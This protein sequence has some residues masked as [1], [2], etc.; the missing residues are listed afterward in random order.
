MS[1]VAHELR[2][3]TDRSILL[4][5]ACMMLVNG[6]LVY[7][8]VYGP[9]Q[10]YGPDSYKK[11]YRLISEMGPEDAQSYLEETLKKLYIIHDLILY[12]DFIPLSVNSNEHVPN[13]EVNEIIEWYESGGYLTYT[14]SIWW[15]I[16][17]IRSVLQHVKQTI[18]YDQYLR[19]ME[20]YANTLKTVSIFADQNTFGYR[21]II[22]T[23][24]DFQ[25]LRGLTFPPTQPQG[26]DIATRNFGTDLIAVIMIAAACLV[27]ITREKE[28]NIMTLVRTTYRGTISLLGAKCMAVILFSIAVFTLLYSINGI[29]GYIIYGFGNLYAPIQSMPDFYGSALRLSIG[30][31]LGLWIIAKLAVYSLIGMLTIMIAVVVHSS[32]NVFIWL[33]VLFGASAILYYT[34]PS[35]SPFNVIKY[36]NLIHFLQTDT[37]FSQYLNLNIAGYPFNY[38]WCFLTLVPTLTIVSSAVSFFVFSRRQNRGRSTVWIERIFGYMESLRKS[39]LFRH[40]SLLRHESYK[41]FIS[42]RVWIILIGFAVLQIYLYEPMVERIPDIDS[43]YYKKYMLQL[44]GTWSPEKHRQLLDE[45]ER[46][47]R[48]E[49]EILSYISQGGAD[50]QSYYLMISKL[51]S[52]TAPR[53]GLERAIQTSYELEQRMMERG[54]GW[55]LYAEGYKRLTAERNNTR[56]LQLGILLFIG[57]IASLTAIFSYEYETGMQRIVRTSEG[58]RM[59]LLIRKLL[60]GTIITL[61]LFLGVYVP[62]LLNVLKAYGTKSIEAPVYS[63]S[64]LAEVPWNLSIAGYLIVVHLIRLAGAL[65]A[66]LIIFSLAMRLQS[67]ILTALACSAV[68]V[69]P[70]LLSLI[71]IP[72][73]DYILLTPYISGNLLFK[74]YEFALLRSVKNLYFWGMMGILAVSIPI[75]VRRIAF[76]WNRACI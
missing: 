5:L 13:V 4:L 22:K 30:G 1:L 44:E 40:T 7:L 41:V 36:L 10:K 25:T 35:A 6:A 12:N 26:I 55:F 38:V 23:P 3:L 63:M 42:H 28:R 60:I 15:E 73:L 9:D 67:Y 49:Q 33:V 2:K 53:N 62:E 69:L 71:G 76:R 17:F 74:P 58:G 20:E 31:Y 18:K 56:D 34:I 21:N 32:R 54:D 51:A 46:I 48:E 70:I 29:F 61:V 14:S 45:M 27:L 8:Q 66:M 75:L 47:E 19:D 52:V 50:D 43:A 72:W 37:L 57:M 65:L 64:H 59:K 24:S 16:E 11:I 68:L 39:S